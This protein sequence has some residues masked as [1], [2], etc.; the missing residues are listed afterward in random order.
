M[1]LPPQ[2]FARPDSSS[3]FDFYQQPRL[4]THIDDAAIQAVTA[5]YREMLPADGAILDLMSSW[6][7]HLPPEIQYPC[8]VGLGMNA[9]ELEANPRLSDTVVQSLNDDPTLPFGD[10]EFDGVTC[11]VS[12]QYLT[13]PVEVWRE[14][15][16]VCRPDAP[17]IITFSNR[18]FPTKAVL[19]WQMLDDAGHGA[20]V[21]KYLQEAQGWRDIQFLDRSPRPGRSDP[22]FA[23]TARRSGS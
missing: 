21:T 4:V 6:V 9:R 17:V 7:S 1:N 12:V 23:V 8:V 18:C 11:C 14:V 16:R 15:A 13:R 5:L 3:D 20:L 10:A 19:A 2:A 22:L